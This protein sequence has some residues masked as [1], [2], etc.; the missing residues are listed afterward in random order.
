MRT[1]FPEEVGI[2]VSCD[3]GVGTILEAW[4]E[5]GLRAVAYKIKLDDGRV[6]TAGGNGGAVFD[7]A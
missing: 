3:E 5:P 1:L 6:V 2:R 7:H 4:W